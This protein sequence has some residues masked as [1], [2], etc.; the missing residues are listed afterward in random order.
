MMFELLY[1]RGWYFSRNLVNCLLVGGFYFRRIEF[2]DS[3]FFWRFFIVFVCFE[4][5]LFEYIKNLYKLYKDN[6]L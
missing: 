5:L 3:G 1:L 6:Y 2:E 4:L